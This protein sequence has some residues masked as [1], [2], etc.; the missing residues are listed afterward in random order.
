V[1]AKITSPP[2]LTTVLDVAPLLL[3]LDE[4]AASVSAATALT[5]KMRMARARKLPAR[6]LTLRCADRIATLPSHAIVAGS[7]VTCRS[8]TRRAAACPM[9]EP[10]KKLQKV[11]LSP[12]LDVLL[13]KVK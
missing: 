3:E 8:R 6:E 4:Q 12:K 7:T 2:G 1:A 5:A 9:R 10:P 13:S 11:G